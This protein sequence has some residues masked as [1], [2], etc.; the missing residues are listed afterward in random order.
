MLLKSLTDLAGRFNHLSVRERVLILCTGLFLFYSLW[1]FFFLQPL[2]KMRLSALSEQQ[3]IQNELKILEKSF[4]ENNAISNNTMQQNYQAQLMQLYET[5]REQQ[6]AVQKIT[7]TLIPPEQMTTVIESLLKKQV[8]LKLI[9]L[10]NLAAHSL[11]DTQ[12]TLTNEK[13]NNSEIENTKSTNTPM[14]YKHGLSIEFSGTY[15]DT[16]AYLSDLEKA[17]WK[18][19][20]DEL[21]IDTINYPTLVIKIKVYTLSLTADWLGVEMRL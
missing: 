15:L 20:W 14:V 5:L 1:N 12:T 7:K 19:Y 2:E 3:A 18:F 8:S 9:K 16:L 6:E 4:P 13:A 11:L 10:Q 21:Q 17:N